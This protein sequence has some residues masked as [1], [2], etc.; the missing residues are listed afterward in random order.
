M[1]TKVEKVVVAKVESDLLTSLCLVSLDALTELGTR[2]KLFQVIHNG[3][4]NFALGSTSG[5]C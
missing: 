1:A 3:P 2:V 4:R 5:F